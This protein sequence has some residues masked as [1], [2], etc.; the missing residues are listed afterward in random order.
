MWQSFASALRTASSSWTNQTLQPLPAHSTTKQS[1]KHCVRKMTW[2]NRL[3]TKRVL[4]STF[5]GFVDRFCKSC[6]WAI[7]MIYVLCQ[8]RSCLI[9]F[10]ALFF[11]P[12]L[13]YMFWAVFSLSLVFNIFRG[14]FCYHRIENKV[15]LWE[16]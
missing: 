10:W 16:K 2:A 1:W 13:T 6:R 8:C 7:F 14:K 5:R 15:I 12:P 9:M 11:L 3:Y 4:K